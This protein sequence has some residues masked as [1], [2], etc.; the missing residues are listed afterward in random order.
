MQRA[1]GSVGKF[2]VSLSW[3]RSARRY[4]DLDL[5]LFLP[6]KYADRR[7]NNPNNLMGDVCFSKKLKHHFELDVDMCA[8]ASD[9]CP[10]KPV[11]NIV[12][13]A[14]SLPKRKRRRKRVAPG[15]YTIVVQNYGYHTTDGSIG[16]KGPAVPFDVL[17]SMDGNK[18]LITGLCTKRNTRMKKSAVRVIRVIIGPDGSVMSMKKHKP[19][20]DCGYE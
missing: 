17:F 19:M 5:H 13:P 15:T 12:F 20:G 8:G 16:D 10:H 7:D 3:T 2:S 14:P 4:A 9:S 18:T 1:G 11:E 6:A